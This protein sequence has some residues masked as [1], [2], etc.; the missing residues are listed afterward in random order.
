MLYA[1]EGAPV[2]LERDLERLY[3]AGS[4]MSYLAYGAEGG[5]GLRIDGTHYFYRDAS[6]LEE[7]REMFEGLPQTAR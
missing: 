7:E 1:G 6:E 4:G 5:G 2:A 3:A